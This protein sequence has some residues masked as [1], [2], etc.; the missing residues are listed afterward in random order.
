[1]W[2]INYIVVM[3]IRMVLIWIM[4]CFMTYLDSPTVIS[5]FYLHLIAAFSNQVQL[6]CI[7]IPAQYIA[8]VLIIG[9]GPFS[10][11]SSYPTPGA[12]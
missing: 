12:S 6:Y 7:T 1:M 10:D 2:I 5:I 11:R 8:V 4:N 3:R 9:Q